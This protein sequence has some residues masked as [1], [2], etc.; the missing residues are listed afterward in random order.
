[1]QLEECCKI[2]VGIDITCFIP[3]KE[4][5]FSDIVPP[6]VAV[7]F[8]DTD[9]DLALK[10]PSNTTKWGSKLVMSFSKLLIKESN[11]SNVW[12]GDLYKVKNVALFITNSYFKH[13]LE[14]ELLKLR[15]GKCSLTYAHTPPLFTLLGSAL[16]ILYPLILRLFFFC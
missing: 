5:K 8:T 2:C 11:S 6:S 9:F 1:M 10:S 13:S 15:T 3:Y 14:Y 4:V 7:L 16:N 12:L